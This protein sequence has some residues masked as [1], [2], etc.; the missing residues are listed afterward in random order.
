MNL[1]DTVILKKTIAA[2]LALALCAAPALAAEKLSAQE[3]KKLAPGRYAVNVMGIVNLTVSMR[4]N[5][6]LTGVN[7]KD[8]DRGVW[9]VRGEKLCVAWNDWLGGKQRCAALKGQN[10]S[11]S[12]GGLWLRKI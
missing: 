1:E 5:G 9:S 3:L 7:G 6:T 10:G 2:A 8:K 11:Y 12:G 4:P